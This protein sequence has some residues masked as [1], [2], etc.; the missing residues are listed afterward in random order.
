ME[1]STQDGKA[2]EIRA[3]VVSLSHNLRKTDLPQNNIQQLIKEHSV[4]KI[5]L[6]LML[7]KA[8]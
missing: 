2:N 8:V 6:S 3:N 1:A 5:E 7:T 4:R